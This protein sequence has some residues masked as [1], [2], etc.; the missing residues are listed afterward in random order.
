MGALPGPRGAA[1]LSRELAERTDPQTLLIRV[2]NRPRTP[3]HAPGPWIP[4]GGPGKPRKP[5]TALVP[6]FHKHEKAPPR[7]LFGILS[8]C[9]ARQVGPVSGGRQ[10]WM[11][12]PLAQESSALLQ[13]IALASSFSVWTIA[14]RSYCFF[15]RLPLMLR[16]KK[17]AFDSF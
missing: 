17:P 14:G 4:R 15:I 1:G 7:G 3:K 2:F 6:G 8:S 9:R 12:P 5:R 11:A 16:L 10:L 13:V